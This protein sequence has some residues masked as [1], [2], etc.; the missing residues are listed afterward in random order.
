MKKHKHMHFLSRKESAILFSKTN[1]IFLW[2]IEKLCKEQKQCLGWPDQCVLKHMF[3]KERMLQQCFQARCAMHGDNQWSKFY[4][5]F[6]Q[7]TWNIIYNAIIYIICNNYIYNTTIYSG[8]HWLGSQCS[9]LNWSCLTISWAIS[10]LIQIFV[11]R[12][13]N[14]TVLVTCTCLNACENHRVCHSGYFYTEILVSS[15]WKM[16]IFI[17]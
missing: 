6:V 5:V 9:S 7:V 11:T 10:S 15:P 2:Y 13:N 4:F 14:T 8:I 3:C 16:F 12:K 1:L 17:I